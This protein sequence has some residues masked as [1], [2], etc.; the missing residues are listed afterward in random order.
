[1]TRMTA[2]QFHP[3]ATRARGLVQRRPVQA[4]LSARFERDAVPLRDVLYRHAFRMSR[5]HSDAEDLVQEAMMKAYAGFHAFR[6][7]TDI[8]SAMQA[9]PQHSATRCITPM[10]KGCAITRSRQS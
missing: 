4:E 8:R 9:L 7:D 6:P 2:A 5:N 10:S 3:G 1:M